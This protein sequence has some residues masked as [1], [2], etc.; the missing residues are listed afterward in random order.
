MAKYLVVVK[1]DISDFYTGCCFKNIF[2]LP[3]NDRYLYNDKQ[4]T[5]QKQCMNKTNL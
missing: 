4:K 3:V 5:K 1:T 2:L